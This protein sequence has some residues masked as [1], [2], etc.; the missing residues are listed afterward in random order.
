MT[1]APITLPWPPSVNSYWRSI[2]IQ[3]SS[4]VLISEKGRAYRQRVLVEALVQRFP[5]LGDI[6]IRVAITAHPPD[7]RR[8]D[9]DNILKSLLDALQH[10]G[11]YV[12]DSQID[13]LRIVR[14]PRADDG[15]VTVEVAPA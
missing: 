10:A 15:Y 4:R 14:A 7:R 8:R 1:T 5:K 2:T 3:G 6:R 9:L 13:E 12:D 11:V